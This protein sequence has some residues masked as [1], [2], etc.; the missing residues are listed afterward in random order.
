MYSTVVLTN[1]L[2]ADQ[3]VGINVTGGNTVTVNGI[4]WHD[5][6][7]T[8]S[9]A[10][11]AVVTVQNQHTGDP[12]FALDGYHLT[13]GSAAIDKGVDAGV[14]DDIDGDPRSI[15]Q[16]DIGADEWWRTRVHLPIV[17]R[18]HAP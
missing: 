12:A 4:L 3:A 17:L 13:D 5:T 8:V 11:T 2:L 14:A 6:P 18:N 1:T 10:I 7:I 15:G 16:P 9:Q